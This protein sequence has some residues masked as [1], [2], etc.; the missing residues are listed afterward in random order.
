MPRTTTGIS[1][2]VATSVTTGT[3]GTCAEAAARALSRPV[4]ATTSQPMAI[5]PHRPATPTLDKVRFFIRD[6][7]RLHG[8]TASGLCGHYMAIRSVPP[9]VPLDGPRDAELTQTRARGCAATH[10][11]CRSAVA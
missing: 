4:S 3:G 2:A 8:A 9:T 6:T 11:D 1:L 10:T 7:L 5:R